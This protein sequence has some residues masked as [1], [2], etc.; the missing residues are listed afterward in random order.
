MNDQANSRQLP[1]IILFIMIFDVVMLMALP[2]FFVGCLV[3]QIDSLS[4]SGSAFFRVRVTVTVTVQH[5]SLMA[6]L[7]SF[8]CCQTSA[9]GSIPTA[10]ALSF[11]LATIDESPYLLALFGAY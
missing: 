1:V 2:W 8:T 4:L 5:E 10:S 3:A 11:N 6:S 7:F 9:L